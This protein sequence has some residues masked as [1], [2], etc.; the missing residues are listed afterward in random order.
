M[1]GRL[2]CVELLEKCCCDKKR[3]KICGESDEIKHFRLDI[4]RARENLTVN[5]FYE[6]MVTDSKEELFNIQQ[7]YRM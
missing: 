5:Y 6:G 7:L 3:Q 1:E 4:S 2:L